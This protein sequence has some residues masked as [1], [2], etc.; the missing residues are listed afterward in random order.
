[1]TR[2]LEPGPPRIP[3]HLNSNFLN[4]PP[5]FSGLDCET[6]GTARICVGLVFSYKAR[7]ILWKVARV[8]AGSVPDKVSFSRLTQARKNPRESQEGNGRYT[9][10][11]G[12]FYPYEGLWVNCPLP[13][14]RGLGPIREEE[15]FFQ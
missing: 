14:H 8:A 4:R 9:L 3:P 1:M 11:K 2:I 15:L 12:P 7:S 10:P 6:A 5:I 13:G